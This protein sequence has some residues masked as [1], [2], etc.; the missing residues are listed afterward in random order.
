MKKQNNEP[1]LDEVR[2]A[3][4]KQ[5]SKDIFDTWFLGAGQ[6]G[7]IKLKLLPGYTPQR[8]NGIVECMVI[9]SVEH[10]LY[11]IKRGSKPQ[12]IRY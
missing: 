11:Q 6:T 10:P 4:T 1:T 9:P 3:F 12:T 7:E 2:Q 8:F 5:E